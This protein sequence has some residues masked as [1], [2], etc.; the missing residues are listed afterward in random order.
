MATW[1]T[2]S[3]PGSL[4]TGWVYDQSVMTYDSLLDPVTGNTVSYD[5]IGQNVNWQT[6]TK[7]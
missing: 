2:Q 6:I 3:K 5:Q 4:G 7:N 1:T